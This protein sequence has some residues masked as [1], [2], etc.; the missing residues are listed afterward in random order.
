MGRVTGAQLVLAGTAILPVVLYGV[1]ATTGCA[2]SGTG[3][4]PTTSGKGKSVDAPLADATCATD[5]VETTRD[6]E[7]WCCSPR[8]R[9]CQ[10]KG[11]PIVDATCATAGE[12]RV[13]AT[14]SYEDDVC[15]GRSFHTT[16]ERF[17]TR[18]ECRK[19]RDALAW[20]YVEP[21]S[22]CSETVTRSCDESR[23]IVE[24]SRAATGNAC[25]P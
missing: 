11:S 25:D 18:Y 15:A 13:G 14:L 12:I 23:D 16:E 1:L 21:T 10:A 4:T 24:M 9:W 2:S 19:D 3:P 17:V 7:P 22:W 5:L 8:M 20:K 6:G